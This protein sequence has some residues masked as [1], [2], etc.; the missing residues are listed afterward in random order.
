ML[1]GSLALAGCMTPLDRARDEIEHAELLAGA[2]LGSTRAEGQTAAAYSYRWD[3]V[4]AQARMEAHAPAFGWADLA[5]LRRQ[6]AGLA[7]KLAA[8]LR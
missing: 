4:A 6:L 1:L 8:D 5:E 2:A 7:G 3:V